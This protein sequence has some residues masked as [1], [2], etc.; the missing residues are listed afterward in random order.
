[1]AALAAP[2]APPDAVPAGAVLTTATTTLAPP[3][4]HVHAWRVEGLTLASFTGAKVGQRLGSPP[5]QACGFE[6]RLWLNPNGE[7]EENKG[8]VGVFCELLTP[9]ATVHISIRTS[10]L[11]RVVTADDTQKQNCYSTCI[12]LPAGE[13]ASVLWGLDVSS[14]AQL[15][16]DLAKFV[17]GG[18]MTV[19]ATLRLAGAAALANP[20]SLP[21]PGLSA[22]LGALLTSGQG[23]DVTLLCGGERLEAHSLLLCARSP[24]FAAQ[25]ED[26]PLRADAAAVPVP[27]E[28]TPQT[29]RRLLHFLYTDKLDPESAEEASHLLNAADH[30]NVPRLFA[31]CERTLCSALAIDTVATTLTLAD[32]HGA[33][34][35]KHAALRFLVANAVAVMATPGWAHLASARPLLMG[36]ALHTLATGAP[37]VAPAVQPPEAEGD[38]GDAGDGA[39]RRVRRRT[40]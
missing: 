37:P 23:A 18:V 27:P 3:S 13:D 4:V 20:V 40:R 12:P 36:E 26:G 2:A 10:I 8:S 25:L 19:T 7:T 1:M 24:V 38:A 9:D 33:T 29:L 16:A 21:A 22:A 6:W 11:G 14:H 17:P 30:Y 32:Q 35:L 28:I 34:A 39:A 31:I 5:F 15:A